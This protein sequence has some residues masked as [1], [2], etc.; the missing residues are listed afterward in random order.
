MIEFS[1]EGKVAIVT[2]GAMGIGRAIVMRLT[3]AGAGV[4]IVDIDMDAVRTDIQTVQ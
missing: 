4:M 3:E 1:M 2:G